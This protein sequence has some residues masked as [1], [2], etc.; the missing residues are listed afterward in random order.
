[1]FPLIIAIGVGILSWAGLKL[2]GRPKSRG[3]PKDPAQFTMLERHVAFF[4]GPNWRTDYVT[5]G[6]FIGSLKELGV[7]PKRYVIG[8]VIMVAGR[9]K[10]TSGGWLRPLVV[11]RPNVARMIHSP[12]DTGLY[13]PDG[14][15]RTDPDLSST[16]AAMADA[17]L[18]LV[19]EESALA[20]ITRRNGKPP[21]LGQKG[22]FQLLFEVFEAKRGRNE[23]G[24]KGLNEQELRDLYQGRLL[25]DLVGRKAPWDI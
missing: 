19:T 21:S 18:G 22:E 17:R 1:M 25:F 13:L 12:A 15:L 16:F 7:G 4:Q 5:L 2:T 23:R 10:T 14:S 6:D 20:Y 24:R 8:L 9:S 3:P 11:Y